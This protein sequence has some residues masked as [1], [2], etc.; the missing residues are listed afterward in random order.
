MG[1]GGGALS[2]EGVVGEAGELSLEI[3]DI[4][5]SVFL[6]VEY[7]CSIMDSMR[8]ASLRSMMRDEGR[9]IALIWEPARRMTVLKSPVLQSWSFVFVEIFNGQSLESLALAGFCVLA[10]ANLL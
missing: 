3:G 5:E 1:G 8:C 10:M 7:A 9:P 4:D 6:L 2:G